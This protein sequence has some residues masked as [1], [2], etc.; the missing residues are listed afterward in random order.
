MYN[1]T[2]KKDYLLIALVALAGCAVGVWSILA[3]EPSFVI[4]LL[5]CLTVGCFWSS[6][7]PRQ[8]RG[9]YAFLV[10]LFALAFVIRVVFALGMH[11]FLLEYT[12]TPYLQTAPGSIPDDFKFDVRGV[13][14]ADAWRSGNISAEDIVPFHGRIYFYILGTLY[15]LGDFIGG[16]STFGIILVHCLIGALVCVYVAKLAGRLYG[17]PVAKLSGIIAMLFPEFIFYSSVLLRD[18]LIALLVIFTVWQLTEYIL[19]DRKLL[20]LVVVASIVGYVLPQLREEMLIGMGITSILCLLV[21]AFSR[22]MFMRQQRTLIMLSLPFAVLILSLLVLSFAWDS[23]DNYLGELLRHDPARLMANLQDRAKFGSLSAR[24][25]SLPY[26]LRF[27]A[28]TILVILYPFPPWSGFLVHSC[29]VQNIVF[30][31][32]GLVWYVL[33]PYWFAGLVHSV[34]LDKYHL[35]PVYGVS[36]MWIVALGLY[37]GYSEASRLM[38]MPLMLILAAVGWHNRRRY[39]QFPKLWSLFLFIIFGIYSVL[40]LRGGSDLGVIVGGSF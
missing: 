37:T 29:R 1:A 8:D 28:Q 34:R 27:P 30:A 10:R 19:R 12:G 2:I 21:P 38:V 4:I 5:L 7:L 26:W 18:T 39:T 6:Y 25:L 40:K 24:M 20:R 3:S 9:K 16:T 22:R 35:F 32:S 31:F 15:R 36:I 11:I 23:I 33:L 14:V 13:V 17:L